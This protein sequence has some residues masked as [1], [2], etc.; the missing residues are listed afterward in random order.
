MPLPDIASPQEWRHRRL[1]L[2]DREKA[3]TQA[4]D[5]LNADRR[6]LPMVRVEKEY[7]FEGPEGAASLFDLFHGRKQLVL[8]HFMFDPSWDDGCPSCTDFCDEISD[9]LLRHLH[10]RDTTYVAVSRAPFSKVADYKARRGWKFPWFSSHGSEFNYD[11]HVTLDESVAPIEVNYRSAEEMAASPQLSWIMQ[12][13]QPFEMPGFSC[14]LR[15]GDTV[16]HTYFT[17]ARG[18]EALIGTYGFLDMTVLGRQEDWEEPKGRV[19]SPR[20][21]MPIF[22][23]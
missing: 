10:S 2:L 14:F 9:S 20:P 6:R 19:G 5:E 22:P 4:R 12:Q 15:D 8:Q 17:S 16:F 1:A 18:A 3:L 23:D 21:A 11:F 13:D 7:A